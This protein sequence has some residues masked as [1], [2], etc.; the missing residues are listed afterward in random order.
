MEK[1][2]WHNIEASD[3][4]EILNVN[5]EKGLDNNESKQRLNQYG[6]NKLPE[7]KKKSPLIRF[8][9]QFN[10]VLIYLLL[11]SAVITALMDHWV[12]TFVIFGVVFI[13]AVVGFIQEGKAEK[14]LDGIKKM[15]SLSAIILREGK[16]EKINSEELVPGDI[17][18][19]KAGDKVPADIRLFFEK[20]LRVEESPLT[21]E[22]TDVSKDIRPIA[23]ESLVGDKRNMVFSGTLVT[24]GEGRGI[25]IG[26]G[27]ETEIGKIT[28]MISEVERITTPL[29][30]KMDRFAKY[31]SVFILIIAA[32]FF[33]FGYMVRGNSAVEMFLTTVSLVVAAI[34]EGLPAVMTIALATGVQKMARRNAIVR[35][36]PSVETLGAVNVICSDKT[37]TLTK[38]EMTA[39]DIVTAERR[40]I[41]TGT[42]YDPEGSI[43]FEEKAFN[44]KDDPVL[45]LLIKAAR[46]CNDSDI[47][48]DEN[49]QWQ[50]IGTATEGALITL[51]HKA[52]YS[53]I[54]EK[55]IDSIPFESANKFMATLNEI[56]GEKYIFFKGAP[57]RIIEYCGEEM[58]LTG[59]RKIDPDCWHE[60]MET[61]AEKGQRVLALA[62]KRADDLMEISAES[63]GND[64]IFLGFVGIIDPPREEALQAIKDCKKAGI[65]VIMITGDHAV[66][67]KAISNQLGI[68]EDGK[69]VTGR[70]L[71]K[72]TD[73]DLKTIVMES[74]VFAR[75]EPEHKL[76]LV[77]ALQENGLLCAMT[78]DGV[79]DAP[80]LKR[81]NIGV[82]MGIKGTEVS[83]EAAEI[84]LTDDNFA[85]IVNAVEEGRTVYDNIRKT[86]LF[87]LP[88]NG[89]EALVL[90]AAILLGLTMPITPVQILW[91]NMV[92]AVTLA[93]ALVFEPME[94]QVMERPPREKDE[95]IFSKYFIFRTIF[96]SSLI[97]FITFLQYDYFYDGGTHIEYSR[98]VAVNMLAAGQAFYLLN[99][100]KIHETTIG[101][102]FFDNKAVF[103]SMVVLLLLQL[104]FTYLP[105]M[106][107]FFG[108]VPIKAASW[109]FPLLGGLLVFLI[110]EVEKFITNKS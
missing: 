61:I 60:S 37:G 101:R 77:K 108:T 65:R 104:A 81:A 76:K 14:A 106:N 54:E 74:N 34:P 43:F 17:V 62:Y 8:L 1:Y 82:A 26:T 4:A 86:I 66:T 85:T 13:N 36:L 69:V 110:V 96:V 72:M 46:I 42:G 93:L 56:D 44:V 88:T 20:D 95:P 83:K 109:L 24:Y 67:A 38:N 97:G 45:E 51:A 98:T 70:E 40:Y 2:K 48:K 80:A 52:G 102:G 99:C 73:E 92:T 78:G 41:T 19:L 5:T 23:E 39:K 50:T 103:I 18:I 12:D 71:Q 3:V 90:M 15:L 107:I 6:Y 16:I 29:I 27:E 53:K 28:K 59:A 57:E 75:T 31:L 55:R 9:I 64:F 35:R 105:F 63:L 33:I 32:I 7:S 58:T 30:E 21:G 68:S 25:V 49:G 84:V 22:S 87:I 94:K 47:K 89:A 11:V 10:N 91:I 100:R 79:N